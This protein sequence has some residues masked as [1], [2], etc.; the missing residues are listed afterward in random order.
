MAMETV[1]VLA[2]STGRTIVLPPVQEMYLLG[3]P[4]LVDGTGPPKYGFADFFHLDLI[5]GEYPGLSVITMADFLEREGGRLPSLSVPSSS[6]PPAPPAPKGGWGAGGG[7]QLAPLWSYLDS[8]SKVVGVNGVEAF[9]VLPS[10]PSKSSS[11]DVHYLLEQPGIMTADGKWADGEDREGWRKV[12]GDFVGRPQK[13]DATPKER[14]REF[15]SGR[16]EMHVYDPEMQAA[17]VLHFPVDGAKKYRLLTHFYSFVFF[18]DY[19]RELWTKRFVRDHV[20]Y[21]DEIFCAAAV[22]LKAVRDKAREEAGSGTNNP[23]GL[24]DSFHIRRGD[25]QY[26][27]TRLDGAAIL[28]NSVDELRPSGTVFIATDEKDVSVFKELAGSYKVLYLKDFVHLLAGVNPN[29]YGMIDQIVASKGQVFFGTFF[30]TFSGYINR[31]RGYAD[32]KGRQ[33]GEHGTGKLEDSYYFATIDKKHEMNKFLP[34]R[35]PFYSREYPT[36]WRDID[37]DV[38]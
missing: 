21:L 17:R 6:P 27:V 2:L 22:V 13:T 35:S 36:A 7:K 1:L 5:A 16:R 30:S 18:E 32:E 33:G 29:Y 9:F 38:A 20:R 10:S 24:F 12:M 34:I 26:K 8:V 19:K 37:F 23:L 25:F 28:A 31:M 15:W 3:Q 14:F 4:P 11:A